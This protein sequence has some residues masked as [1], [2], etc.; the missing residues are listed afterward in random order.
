MTIL[1]I[2]DSRFLR[3]S[4]ERS[5]VKAGH[6][7]IAVGDGPEGLRQ[8]QQ[9]SP[10]VILLDLMLP[11]MDGTKVLTQLKQDEATKTIPVIVL[12]GLSQK[13]EQKLKMSG[14]AAYFEKSNLQLEKDGKALVQLV[15]QLTPGVSS[16]SS[17]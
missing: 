5:F 15:E 17:D 7:V 14:A 9:M 12:S 2:E 1:V 4:I 13:N 3:T 10:D 6:K 11:M 16:R 8:A